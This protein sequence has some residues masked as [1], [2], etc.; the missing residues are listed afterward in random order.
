M[1]YSD[2]VDAEPARQHVKA[3]LAG[4]MSIIQIQNLSGVDR[5]AVRVLL[6]NFPGRKA[7]TQ[8]RAETASRLLR[9][10]LDRGSCIAG[11]VPAAGT[12]RR[13]QALRALGYTGLYLAER[14]GYGP[15][16]GLQ[17]S[18]KPLVRAVTAHR[19]A[20]L[21]QELA[22][23][24]GPSSRAREYARHRGW[25]LPIWWDD[26]SIDDPQTAPEGTRTYRQAGR[27]LVDDVTLP[28][29]AR[30]A[31]MTRR[32]L[33]TAE[34]AQR[35]G[36]L[37]RYVRRDLLERPVRQIPV[38]EPCAPTD[39]LD[40]VAVARIMAGTLRPIARAPERV[41]AIRQLA[42]SGLNDREIGA[43]IGI[44]AD[45]VLKTRKRNGIPAGVPSERTA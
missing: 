31:L 41:E 27:V 18:R 30:I 36:T 15:H 1:P 13:L 26:D 17:M 33:T 9:T 14:F 8:V 4:G 40:E 43:L 28:R 44:S 11:L 34:I 21:Y 25:L 12:Q 32:G 39:E 29:A 23:T 37:E 45:A 35:I 24:P 42:A 5:T 3:L 10:R 2:Q 38:T 7:S 6:G 22:D 20:E 19:V 16:R